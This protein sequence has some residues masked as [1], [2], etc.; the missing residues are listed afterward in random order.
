MQEHRFGGTFILHGNLQ[1][2]V[3]SLLFYYGLHRAINFRRSLFDY[4]VILQYELLKVLDLRNPLVGNGARASDL[5]NIAKLVH[6]RYLTIRVHR[7]K[8]PSEIGNLQNLE[9]FL[10]TGAFDEVMLPETIWN[11][12]SL[13]F[14]QTE[15]EFFSF[16]HYSQD[17]FQNFSQLDNLKSISA[18]PLCHGDDVEKFILRRLTGIQKLGCKFSNSWDDCTGCNFFPVLDFLSELE[19][20]KVFFRGKTLYPCKF[21]FPENLKKLTL[22][23]ARLPWDEISVIGQ[24]PNLEVLKLLNNA[25]EGQQWDMREGEFQKLKFLKLDSLD[26]EQWNASSEDLHCLEKLVL[27]N[28]QEL[29]EIPSAF[30]EIP[31]LQLIEMKW[32]SSSAT[33]S[34]KQILEEQR[35]MSN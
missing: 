6:L 27:I 4:D 28:C 19:S 13:R 21:S 30:G 8:I 35:D 14:I 10:I 9:T 24:L 33:E 23:N 34:V 29:E 16:E 20:L 12:V 17:F 5:V 7:N 15:Y 25:F 31:T 32:C 2:H 11:L 26:I 3:Q 18:L 1:K 22:L